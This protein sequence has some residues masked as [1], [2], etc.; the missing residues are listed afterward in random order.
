LDNFHIVIY[1][2]NKLLM[3]SRWNAAVRMD[4]IPS[5]QQ[6]ICPFAFNDKEGCKQSL[7]SDHQ[8]HM[9]T[10]LCNILDFS[11]MLLFAK[12]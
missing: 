7:R 1:P 6:A 3:H 9:Y 2:L 4:P 5:K 8:I 11:G 10:A 12:S